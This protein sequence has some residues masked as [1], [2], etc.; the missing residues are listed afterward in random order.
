MLLEL[1]CVCWNCTEYIRVPQA[2]CRCY[3]TRGETCLLLTLQVLKSPCYEHHCS[4]TPKTAIR[5]VFC[6][7]VVVRSGTAGDLPE[8]SEDRSPVRSCLCHRG[9]LAGRGAQRALSINLL[10]ISSGAK[11]KGRIS[12]TYMCHSA[13]AL[14]GALQN[15]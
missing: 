3:Q 9:K 8:H 11:G 10:C 2:P 12:I 1:S 5:S 14:N 4:G 15:R 13:T 6:G 7:N